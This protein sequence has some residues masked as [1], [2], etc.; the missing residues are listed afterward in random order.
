M[1]GTPWAIS[2]V[3]PSSGAGI[4]QDLRVFGAL[5]FRGRG[6]PTALTIQNLS[7]VKGIEPVPEGVFVSMLE[8]LEEE[9]RPGAIKIGLFPESLGGALRS[10]LENL[11]KEIP[12]VLDPVF[13]SG[14]GCSFWPPAAYREMARSLFPLITLITPN[15]PEA[16]E[17]SGW[18]VERFPDDLSLMA[19]RIHEQYGVPSILIKGGHYQGPGPKTDLLWTAGGERLFLHP[20]RE[21]PGVHGG[22]CTLSSLIAGLLLKNGA[23]GLDLIV[24]K[25]LSLYQ[26]ML[27]R[28]RGESRLVLDPLFV[29]E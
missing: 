21:I 29:R 18:S 23:P 10:F 17:L 27:G 11:P 24:E 25:S 14:T 16:Q 2:G 7:V 9:E 22:G 26:Q 12:R 4:F 6:V 1:S 28:A 20:S 5:G 8:T 15:L 19:R 3:D 13:R